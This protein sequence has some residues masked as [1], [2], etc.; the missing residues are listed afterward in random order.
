MWARRPRAS[1]AYC[2]EADAGRLRCAT[3]PDGEPHARHRTLLAQSARG[4]RAPCPNR[5]F[6]DAAHACELPARRSDT[7]TGASRPRDAPPAPPR[8]HDARARSLALALRARRPGRSLSLGAARAAGAVAHAG[9]AH[10]PRPGTAPLA[11]ALPAPAVR[12]T[13]ARVAVPPRE[14][15]GRDHRGLRGDEG[16]RGSAASH[17]GGA[18]PRDPGG[19]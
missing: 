5:Y 1:A 13:W 15:R 4:V 16:R 3:P 2:T 12:G 9:R 17:P 10:D 6:L 18:D 19:G 11:C 7:A 8:A 14:A